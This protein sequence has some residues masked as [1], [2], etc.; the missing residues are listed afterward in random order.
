MPRGA[1]F[2]IG[3][4][5]EN[6]FLDLLELTYISYFTEKDKKS[7]KLSECILTLDTLKFLISVAWEGKVISNRH[8]EEIS[9]KLEEVGKMFGGWKKNLNPY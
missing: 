8:C 6:K 9:I 4:R 2:T 3:T 5:I 7:E 1:R